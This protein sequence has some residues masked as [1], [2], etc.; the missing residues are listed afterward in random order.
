MISVQ[1]NRRNSLVAIML[2]CA[3]GVPTAPTA[4]AQTA[5]ESRL[6]AQS[7]QF[8]RE[9]VQVTQGVHVAVGYGMANSVLIEGDSGVIIVDTMESDAAAQEVKAA[10]DRVTTK[11]M[12]AIIY[13]HN[14]RDHTL[15]SDVF[16]GSGRPAVYANARFTSE[17]LANSPVRA[18]IGIRSRR[19][20]GADLPAQ[21]RPNL[22][23]GPQLRIDSAADSFLQPTITFD[24]ELSTVI[25]GRESAPPT[26]S[27]RD[28]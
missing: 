24:E 8:R 11:P 6:T 2:A 19:Q 20:F 3:L 12:V 27:R 4:L 14:H 28:W 9:I 23:I 5:A 1:A 17:E 7:D 16:A 13:T 22:G 25:A 15:G 26:R 18:A 10:F 21:D